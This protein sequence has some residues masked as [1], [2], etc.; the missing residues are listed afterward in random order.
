M[1][2]HM[3]FL[4][5][6]GFIWPTLVFAEEGLTV[7]EDAEHQ[8]EMFNIQLEQKKA[9]T[10]F[11][12][13]RQM[14]ELQLEKARLEI[15]HARRE[16]GHRPGPKPEGMCAI[17]LLIAVL[18]RILAPIWI[19]RD[20]RQRNAGSVILVLLGIL[21]GLAGLLTYAVIRLGDANTSAGARK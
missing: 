3:L 2:K 19:Y 4:L 10:D 6:A 5:A 15:E 8:L 16:P 11:E 18:N 12:F 7:I 21:G 14:R 20:M 9:E 17:I 13:G 1:K